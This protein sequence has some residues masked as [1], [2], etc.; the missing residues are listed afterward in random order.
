MEN[1]AFPITV[2]MDKIGAAL[3]AAT[4]DAIDSRMASYEVKSAIANV[5]AK[6]VAEGAVAQ[7]LQAAVATLNVGALTQKLEKAVVGGTVNVIRETMAE[8]IIRM[9]N[10]PVYQED[11]RQRARAEILA[12]LTK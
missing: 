12:L 9:R 10:I 7:A 5:V 2:D 6:E 8:L 1:S 11:Q 4:S 3:Q